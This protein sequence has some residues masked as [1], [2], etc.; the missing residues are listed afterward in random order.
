MLAI[1]ILC[2]LTLIACTRVPVQNSSEK[3]QSLLQ[4][5]VQTATHS[6]STPP[7]EILP[8]VKQPGKSFSLPGAKWV[9][10]TF[11]NCA[12]A[13]TSMLLQYFGRT[14]SQV[15]TKNA[16]RTNPNDKNVFTP[17]IQTYLKNNFNLESKL[18]FGGDLQLLKTL[19][20][21]GFYVMVEDWL[22]PGEDIGHN[23][24]IRGYDD[25]RQVVISDDSFIAAGTTF[26][27]E[28]FYT[29]QWKAFNYEYLVVYRK[30]QEPLLK[31]VLGSR[32]NDD[33]MWQHAVDVN[34]RET[35][36]HPQDMYAWFNLGSSYYGQGQFSKAKDAFVRAKAIGWPKRMLWYQ[37][38]P[39][40]TY[41]KLGEYQ[42][43]LTL[44][45]EGLAGNQEFAELHYE[46]AIAYKGL[47][48]LDRAK[49]EVRTTLQYAPAY[50]PALELATHL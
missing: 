26:P 39:I 42:Q 46:A 3:T 25:D 30:D 19:F 35:Q 2:T 13:T 50:A 22:H 7:P 9:P 14:I 12:P 41:N 10:Q 40:Q 24:I 17:E 32:W 36:E 1:I 48:Q 23:T 28:A 29:N 18:G 45:N 8:K 5:L 38:Q 34:T 21:N 11:N 15:E 33:A 16:L 27:Y 44:I 47:G 37:I 43:A 6:G 4:K 20:V 31:A 49:D